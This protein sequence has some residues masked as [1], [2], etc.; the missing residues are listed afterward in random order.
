ML[1][2]M[3]EALVFSV[4]ASSALVAGSMVGALIQVPKRLLAFLLAF[5]SG[6]LITAMAFELYHGAVARSDVIR[7]GVAFVAGAAVFIGVDT[8]LDRHVAATTPTGTTPKLEGGAAT[9]EEPTP[10]SA[11]GGLAGFAL[12]AAVTLDGVPENLALGVSIGEGHGSLALL[13]AIFA[14]NF[15]E[16]L[17]GSAQMRASGRTG[18]FALMTW[19]LASALLAIA[20][21]IGYAAFGEATDDTISI[22]LAFAGGAV[23]A[24]LADTLMPEAYREG[25]SLVAFA[26]VAGF[27]LSYVLAPI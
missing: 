5:A 15:P 25:G 27:L 9:I 17:V 1:R 20:C 12:L 7:A 22:P 8:W 10:A 3:Q 23:I 2:C 26:T 13:L 19:L 21:V 14:S 18:A 16:A 11:T 24:S 4:I 6:S